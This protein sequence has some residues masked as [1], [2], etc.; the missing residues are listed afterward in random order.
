MTYGV[1]IG[2]AG[3]SYGDSGSGEATLPEGLGLLLD[4]G[5]PVKNV[6]ALAGSDISSEK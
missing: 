2:W 6:K 3:G 4:A 1:L 5:G